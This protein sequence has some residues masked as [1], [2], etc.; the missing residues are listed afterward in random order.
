MPQTKPQALK[1]AASPLPLL[2]VLLL[3]LALRVWGLTWGLPS[4]T[5]YFSYH[6]DESVML[7]T[8]SVTMNL[9]AGR[10]LPHFYNYGS[11]QLY[12]VCFANTLAALFGAVDIIPKNFDIWYPQW[13]KMYLVG[14]CL[15][16]G[17]GVGTVWA[18]YALGLR[19][20]G[21]RAGLLS[22]LILAI[23]PLHAQHSHFL[24]VDVPATFWVVLSLLWSGASGN[25]RPKAPQSCPFSRRF[26]GLRSGHQ[27]Q[28][29]AGDTAAASRL[30][31]DLLTFPFRE[32]RRM[33]RG[34]CLPL[35][36]P[37]ELS[38]RGAGKR[39]VSKRPAL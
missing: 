23:T 13:A 19:L 11:L 5:H 15:T 26:R 16:V 9:F 24:T 34:R 39:Q 14:R 32:G 38:R 12:L 2:G 20:W 30:L 25:G 7:E 33:R 8:S 3:A 21:R 1:H 35:S 28:H 10:L 29:G 37:L 36:L 17:M 27:V 31:L 22:A 6:P 4:A 18:T